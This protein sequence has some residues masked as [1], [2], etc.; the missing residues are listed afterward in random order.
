M[1]SPI[2]SAMLPPLQGGDLWRL[3]NRDKER[4]VF[5]W[6]K[7]CVRYRRAGIS[8]VA[9]STYDAAV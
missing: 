7:R 5:N 9:V 4:C 6:Y 8:H 1:R 2:R 3:L